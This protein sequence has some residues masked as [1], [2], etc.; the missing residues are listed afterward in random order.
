VRLTFITPLAL[1][2]ALVAIVPL[3]VYLLRER[4]LA[5]VRRALRIA[6]PPIGSQLVLMVAVAAVPALLGLAAAQPVVETTRRVQER[7]DVQ[8]FVVLDVSRSMLASTS[9]GAPTR[10]DRAR[11]FALGL[12]EAFPE[13][14]FGVA[15]LTDRVLPHVFPTTDERVFEAALER[16]LGIEQPPPST[17]YY[18]ALAT[19]LGSLQA[20]PEQ[21]FFPPAAKKRVLV[22]LTDGETQPPDATLAR[23]FEGQPRVATMYVRFGSADER[24]YETGVAEGGYRPNPRSAALLARVAEATHGQV[25]DE[26]DAA[27]AQEA[28][29]AAVGTGETI[30]IDEDSGRLALMPYVTLAALVPLAL[31]LLRRNV[32]WRLPAVRR[33]WRRKRPREAAKVSAARG[34]AQPG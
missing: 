14:P 10:F 9:P 15:S 13:V 2:F 31:I 17:A 33:Q 7:T 34:V 5:G 19:K 6:R 29:R 28:V 8:A 4:R 30:T 18:V 23:A 16:A 32:W 22:V 25:F 27:D 24:I 26:R 12:R 11:S 1:L 20:V 21:N 3:V